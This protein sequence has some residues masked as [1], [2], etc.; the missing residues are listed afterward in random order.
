MKAR[1]LL[2]AAA[3]L[4]L[5]A[6]AC[7]ID[8]PKPAPARLWTSGDFQRLAREGRSFAGI[9]AS[10]LVT[11]RGQ[12]LPLLSAPYADGQRIQRADADGLLVFPAFSEGEPASYTTTEIWQG[13]PAIWL[14]P[15]Y[16]PITGFSG[17]TPQPLAGARPI[18][19]VDTSTRFYGPY[20]R[21]IY[22]VVP[23]GTDPDSLRSAKEVLDRGY[24]L[25]EG[26]GTFCAL[27]P[28]DVQIA[29]A[30]DAPGSER[31]LF[32]D[33]VAANYRLGWVDNKE[34]WYIDFGKNRFTSSED[35]RVN[36]AALFDFALRAPDGSLRALG[37][38]KVGGTGPLRSG[39]P[40][41][42]TNGRPQFGALWRLYQAPLPQAAGV[43]VTSTRPALIA[44][45][46][47]AAGQTG[48]A[49]EASLVP[50]IAAANEARP[51]APN[52]LLRVAANPGCFKDTEGFP[53]SCRWIDSQA[54]VERE[55]QPGTIEDTGFHES[56]PFLT[57]ANQEILP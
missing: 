23:A 40:A 35:G 52:Y 50:T 31:P 29:R 47:A 2:A 36:E 48:T 18:F 19:G 49:R 1:G 22:A 24:Q 15:L 39:T 5:F 51:D 30:T 55:V 41:R 57:F 28:V 37:L 14:Q 16:L 8:E 43:F 33:A 38:P 54:A 3:A 6:A 20:W 42:V 13:F 27:A 17:G 46:L 25:I 11:L 9:P 56:C 53:A 12:P 7:A 21:I 10:S 32:G 4:G 34:T 44:A 26:P 45:V